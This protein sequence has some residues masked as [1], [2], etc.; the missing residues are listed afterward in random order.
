MVVAAPSQG[1]INTLKGGL[2]GWETSMSLESRSLS[3][4]GVPGESSKAEVAQEATVSSQPRSS[5]CYNSLPSQSFVTP[6]TP[7]STEDELPTVM[8]QDGS[9]QLLLVAS[10]LQRLTKEVQELEASST[11]IGFL[12]QEN[13]AKES[14][15]LRPC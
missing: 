8:I 2:Y 4:L 5:E 10:A 15:S 14:A 3:Q 6:H 9:R 13:A 1:V 11:S 12:S 7:S